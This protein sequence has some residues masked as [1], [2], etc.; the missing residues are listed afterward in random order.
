MSIELKLDCRHYR[1]DRPCTFNCRCRCEHYEPM[2]TRVLVIKVGAM[3]DVVRT[4]CILPTLQRVYEPVHVTWITAPNAARM[5]GNHPLIDQMLVFDAEGILTA[6]QQTFDVVLSL[7][8]EAAPAALCESINA[9]DKRGMGLSPT[10]T[11]YPINRECQ[12]YFELG[13]DNDLKFHQKWKT[14]PQLIHQA[15]AMPYGGQRYQLHCDD[16]ALAEARELFEPWRASG[17]PILGVNTGAGQVFANKTFEPAKWVSVCRQL[18]RDSEV[19]LLGGPDEIT[20]NRDIA[21]QLGPEVHVAGEGLTERQFV[22]I[23]DQCDAVVTGDTL[24]LHV[25]I[26]RRVPVVV[27]FGPTCEQEIDLFG[28]GEKVISPCDCKPCYLRRCDRDPSCMDLIEI[29][30]VVEAAHRALKPKSSKKSKKTE[31]SPQTT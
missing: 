20:T 12:A 3:G 31:K 25:A 2:G 15:I 17:K 24:A 22:A 13:L 28:R 23:V 11:V 19:V 9:P 10:G 5:L 7:D 6:Q 21:E 18:M 26:A 8:K 14:Y 4:A 1:G 29:D 30:T 16:D 27:L